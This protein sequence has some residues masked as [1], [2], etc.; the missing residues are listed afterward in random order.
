M[1]SV[2]SLSGFGSQR[3]PVLL[4]EILERAGVLGSCK[5]CLDAADPSSYP[6]SGQTWFDVSGNANDYFLGATGGA[7]ASDP[8]FVGSVGALD[9]YFSF[10]GGDFFNETAAHT[11]DN[12]W[13]KDNGSCSAIALVYPLVTKLAASSIWS[14]RNQ[15]G[16][17]SGV[18]F[19][20]LLTTRL[21]H[22]RHSITT[23]TN[24]G[25]SSTFALNGAAWNYVGWSWHEPTPLMRFHHNLSH[26]S[27]AGTAS[28]DT[29]ASGVGRV[30]ANPNSTG[31]MESGERLMAL[32]LFEGAL[33]E[34]QFSDVYDIIKAGRLQSL[35]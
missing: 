17:D 21:V 14:N 6:G 27:I 35:P 1:L 7:E 11:F 2:N 31:P 29:D 25:I 26:E 34:A 22:F 4:R 8:T 15:G 23:G 13:H 19:E 30:G 12:N 32:A 20:V 33:V 3:D 28:T 5:V 9:A 10:D 16:V 24:E 18:I